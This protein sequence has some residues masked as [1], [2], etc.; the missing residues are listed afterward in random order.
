MVRSLGASDMEGVKVGDILELDAC[1]PRHQLAYHEEVHG[2]PC[3]RVEMDYDNGIAAAVALLQLQPQT[4]GLACEALSI[5]CEG[6][7]PDYRWTILTRIATS[8]RS[9]AVTDWL[10]PK[11]EPHG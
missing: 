2:R 8:L 10:H 3:P 6:E 7:S 1:V 4:A 5:A 9:P 11:A